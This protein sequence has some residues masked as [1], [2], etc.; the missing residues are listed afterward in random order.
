MI[1]QAFSQISHFSDEQSI[2]SAMAACG[3]SAGMAFMAGKFTARIAYK[4]RKQWAGDASARLLSDACSAYRGGYV[5]SKDPEIQTLLREMGGIPAAEAGAAGAPAEQ[6]FYWLGN[7]SDLSWFWKKTSRD[8][9]AMLP[10]SVIDGIADEAVRKQ[11][12]AA[13]TQA[14]LEGLVALEN[15]AYHLTRAGKQYVLKMEFV[16]DRLHKECEYLGVAH[17]GLAEMKKQIENDRI[18]KRLAELGRTGEFEGCDRITL[19]KPTILVD[20]TSDDV[21]RFVVPGTRRTKE[22]DLPKSDLIELDEKTYVGFLRKD[23]NYFVNGEPIQ[24]KELFR[25]FDDKNKKETERIATAAKRGEKAAAFSEKVQKKELRPGDKV[26]ALQPEEEG[27]GVHNYTVERI[28]ESPDGNHLYKLRPE[29]SEGVDMLIREENHGRLFF[30]DPDTAAEYAALAPEDVAAESVQLQEMYSAKEYLEIPA[31]Y[32]EQVNGEIRVHPKDAPHESIVFGADAA[33]VRPDGSAVVQ[34]HSGA[35]YTVRSGEVSYTV[36]QQGAQNLMQ[37]VANPVS[38]GARAAG[39]AA[40]K[41]AA[42][43]AVKTLQTATNVTAKAIPTVEIGTTTTK[44]IM[45]AANKTLSVASAAAQG[46]TQ[47]G[48]MVQK[49]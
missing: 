31:K 28:S 27:L 24:E 25:Y 38:E 2:N 18:D 4:K 47:A 14:R 46:A 33:Q 1:I 20:D 13:M 49:I 29:D 5:S 16:Q 37:G 19:N 22:V 6:P 45:E 30:D 21:A 36:S 8:T 32:V 7:K 43:T 35:S 11:V 15:D 40:A 17:E 10:R 44:I 26:Y 41:T 42:N 3:M 9:S 12:T 34:L 23:K 48:S 39:Q